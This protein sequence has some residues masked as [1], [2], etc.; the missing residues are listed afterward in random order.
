MLERHQRLAIYMEGAVT[1]TIGKMGFGVLRYS[2]Q[3]VAC[4][5]DSEYAGQDVADV[6]DSPRSAPIVASVKEAV[7]KGAEVLVLGI[8]PS[9]GMIPPEWMPVIDEAVA[10]GLS[11]VNGLHDRLAPRYGDLEGNWIW[12]I[13]VEPEDIGVATGRARELDNKRVLMIGTD[14]A[15]GKMTAGLEL[16]RQLRER[17]ISTEFVATGQIGITVTG[18]GIPLDAVRVDYA[19]GAVEKAV[20]EAS[21]DGAEVVIVEGQGAL[22]HPG[23]TANLPLLRGTQPTHLVLCHRAGQTHLTKL[24]DVAIPP[25][26]E[27]IRLYEDL[28]SVGG[29]FPWPHTIGIALN[30]SH[31]DEI[32]A[33]RAIAAVEREVGIPTCDPVR[34]GPDRLANALMF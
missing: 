10:H 4:V 15:V 17:E 9:G 21:A 26:R 30:T 2:P 12:D 18:R 8:A 31:L 13:R 3:P 29:T 7:E 33:V 20:L 14:M 5:I 1:N 32:E 34:F 27:Y 23:S 22:C 28:A 24:P 25:L 6:I 16:Y 19:C 11:V